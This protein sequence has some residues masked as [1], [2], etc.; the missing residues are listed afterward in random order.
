MYCIQVVYKNK[1]NKIDPTK[2]QN[3]SSTFQWQIAFSQDN[4]SA[5]KLFSEEILVRWKV[6]QRST[7]LSLNWH[8]WKPYFV[9]LDVSMSYNNLHLRCS[10]RKSKQLNALASHWWLSYL[11]DKNCKQ[12]SSILC[13]FMVVKVCVVENILVQPWIPKLIFLNWNMLK[14]YTIPTVQ[15]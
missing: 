6:F 13:L 5:V 3:Q 8:F 7:W 9:K 10:K 14:H 11:V 15:I 2:R 4:K 12:V 1:T